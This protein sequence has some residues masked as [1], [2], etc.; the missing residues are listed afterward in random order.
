MS[1]FLHFDG[2]M[3]DIEKK[4]RLTKAKQ[5]GAPVASVVEGLIDITTSSIGAANDEALT[6]HL[7]F[8]DGVRADWVPGFGDTLENVE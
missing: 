7:F 3:I 1:N 5:A 6:I 2:K 8:A 4:V